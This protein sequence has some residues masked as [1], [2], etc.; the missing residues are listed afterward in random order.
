MSSFQLIS[1]A[2]E[3]FIVTYEETVNDFRWSPSQ[4]WSTSANDVMISPVVNVV[5]CQSVRA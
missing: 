2:A 5:W 3:I 1:Y 4:R